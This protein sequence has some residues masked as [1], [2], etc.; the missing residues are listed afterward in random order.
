MADHSARI[1]EIQ[2][3]LRS[4]VSSVATDGTSTTFDLDALRRELRELMADDDLHKARRPVAASI[5]LGGF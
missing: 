1:A 4:G 2:E 5:Y 3:A